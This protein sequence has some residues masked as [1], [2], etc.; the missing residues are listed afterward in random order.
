MEFT[1]ILELNEEYGIN[2]KNGCRYFCYL[3]LTPP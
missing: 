3:H 2:P 1:G